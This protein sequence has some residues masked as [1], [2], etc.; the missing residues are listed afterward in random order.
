MACCRSTWLVLVD[1]LG[2]PRTSS[3][4]VRDGV[5][6]GGVSGRDVVGSG[7]VSGRN[8]VGSGGVSGLMFEVMV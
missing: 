2:V 1:M 4:Q 6:S 3:C 5:G 8:E 7:G